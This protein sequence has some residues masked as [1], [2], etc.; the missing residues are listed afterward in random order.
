MPK[1][2]TE[3]ISKFSLRHMRAAK[4]VSGKN[5]QYR[6]LPVVIRVRHKSVGVEKSI[7]ASNQGLSAVD[8]GV[9]LCWLTKLIKIPSWNSKFE[10]EK[11][12]EEWWP[13]QLF[14]LL[15]S[16][17]QKLFRNVFETVRLPL[18]YAPPASPTHGAD[19]G[20]CRC[21]VSWRSLNV[22]ETLFKYC[23][24]KILLATRGSLPN[25]D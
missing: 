14:V 3:H 24:S 9:I 8:L 12:R 6:Y 20:P 25:Q 7:V 22:S 18:L 11:I 21:I 2:G 16:N 13:G 4:R 15:T 1:Q 5:I 10:D 19:H 23:G 17:Y